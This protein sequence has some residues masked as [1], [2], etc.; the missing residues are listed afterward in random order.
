MMK[1]KKWTIKVMGN[2]IGGKSDG[3]EGEVNGTEAESNGREKDC[4]VS[5]QEINMTE[6]NGNGTGG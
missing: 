6:R 1:V 2:G 5:G 4:H 3:T